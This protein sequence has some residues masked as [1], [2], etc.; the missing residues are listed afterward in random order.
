MVSI[1]FTLIHASHTQARKGVLSVDVH[2]AAAADTLSA[3]PPEG[4][5]RIQL[6]LD[7]DNGIQNH[8]SRLVQVQSVGLHLGLLGR[9]FGVPAVDLEVLHLGLG[10][11]GRLADGSHG[12]SKRSADGT[13]AGHR[14]GRCQDAAGGRAESRHVDVVVRRKRSSSVRV[15]CRWLTSGV[16]RR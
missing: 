16:A 10:L 15:W 14:S 4:Q 5:G 12:T 13:H 3:T 2:C 7:A 9:V 8:R 1:V 11:G 6:V